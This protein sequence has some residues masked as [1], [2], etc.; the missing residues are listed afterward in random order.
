MLRIKEMVKNARYSEVLQDVICELE[1]IEV[2]RLDYDPHYSGYVDIDV[3]LEDGRVFSYL[4]NYGSC[5]R[6]DEWERRDLSH[7]EIME[8]MKTEC[9]YFDSTRQ[10]QKWIETRNQ[11]R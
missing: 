5:S 1:G 2:L 7:N 9:T 10:Y 3:L 8:V 4:Y 6:C 11:K